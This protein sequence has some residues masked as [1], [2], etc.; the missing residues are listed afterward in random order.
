MIL[1]ITIFTAAFAGCIF[2]KNILSPTMK[3]M[4]MVLLVM[5]SLGIAAAIKEDKSALLKN[6]TQLPRKENGN[7][8]YEVNLNVNAG[9]VVSNQEYK[10]MVPEQTL[11]RKEQVELLE[12]A[13]LEIEQE[14]P[15]QNKSVNCIRNRV[16]THETYQNGKVS[17]DWSF[18]N[19]DVMDYEGNII[20][21]KIPDD[22][23]IVM[24]S[25][26]LACK[27]SARSES[28]GFLV[29]PPIKSA[30]E[31]FLQNVDSY[32]KKQE[33]TKAK[34]LR[35]PE[36]LE[37]QKLQWS[38]K[39]E[40]LPEKI[41]ILGVL[42]AI[43]MPLLESSKKQKEKRK[44]ERELTL[45]YPNM[46]SK[47]SLLMGAGMTL[48]GAWMKI[49]TEYNDKRNNNTTSKQEVYEE[50]LIT[51]HELKSGMGEECAY[52]E[53]GDR[54]SLRCYRKL[55]NIL[56]QNLRKGSNG[57]LQLLSSEVEDAFEQRKIIAKKYGEE[58]GTKML[59]PMMIMLGI[60][61]VLLLVPALVS[62]QL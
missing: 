45:E 57:V 7:G 36:K 50:M 4:L 54:C 37:G 61:M 34:F 33:N 38:V 41:V 59:F 58:A 24:A 35:L 49:A 47:L 29:M 48:S 30:E 56:S 1:C 19:Y 14:F 55:G 3:H 46:V 27:E 39:K 6:G 40:H 11:T 51:C 60:I 10:V 5:S 16:I 52:Q 20:T 15:G 32:L 62:F 25:V 12:A 2:G 31:Q 8:V 28:F 18:D 9:D 21:D 44:R 23:I 53:F 43:V 13:M 42:V 17:A 22:G 26:E